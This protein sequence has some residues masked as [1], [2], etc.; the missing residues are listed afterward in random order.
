MGDLSISV[1][2]MRIGEAHTTLGEATCLVK[3][4]PSSNEEQSLRSNT[5]PTMA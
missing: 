1:V 2:T 4:R 5:S 3:E